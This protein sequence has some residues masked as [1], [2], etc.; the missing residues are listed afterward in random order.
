MNFPFVT[1]QLIYV[2]RISMFL[3]D[4][5]FDIRLNFKVRFR[6]ILPPFIIKISFLSLMQIAR[7]WPDPTVPL[8]VIP[9]S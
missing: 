2:I 8:F 1:Q 7:P 5:L 6:Y 9:C 3:K 4:N